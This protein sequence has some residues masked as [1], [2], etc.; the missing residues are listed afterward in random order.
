MLRSMYNYIGIALMS[1]FAIMV[2]PAAQVDSGAIGPE[3]WGMGSMVLFDAL[4][5]EVFAQ[6]THNT[7]VD[8]GE[9]YIITQVFQE[10]TNPAVDADANG[11]SSICVSIKSGFADGDDTLVVGGVGGFDTDDGLTTTN[12]IEDGS[13]S[14]SAGA[15]TATIG[16][17][18]FSAGG[19]HVDDTN[20]ITGIGICQGHTSTP[21]ANCVTAD[22]GAGILF[23]DVNIADTQLN[24][25]ETV[26]ISYTFDISAT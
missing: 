13:L 17:L 2:I 8:T 10:T 6:S 3:F 25:G 16:P 23:A 24:T 26:Q 12:C 18:T 4:G 1:V 19:T 7:I 11:I 20:T 22:G 9:D 14:Y 5:N 15:G 21:F